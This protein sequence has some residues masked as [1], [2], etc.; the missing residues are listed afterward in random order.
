MFFLIQ[1]PGDI[2]DIIKK[3][4]NKAFSREQTVQPFLCLEGPSLQHPR[5][6]YVV[7]SN[8][9]HFGEAKSAFDILFKLL[10][11]FLNSQ[12]NLNTF[13]Y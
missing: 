10:H 2:K 12:Y 7:N 6:F 4:K 5:N 8:Y 13:T 1:I 9:L 3:Q 11:S